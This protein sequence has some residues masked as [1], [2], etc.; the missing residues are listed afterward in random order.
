[1]NVITQSPTNTARG[2]RAV[3]RRK[4]RRRSD[5]GPRWRSARHEPAARQRRRPAGRPRRLCPRPQPSRPPAGRR[6]R[7]RA[8]RQTA[9]DR[10]RA[11]RRAGVR[12]CHPPESDAADL[13]QGAGGQARL[14]VDNPAD[15][16]E[17]RTLDARRV[18]HIQKA[19]ALRDDLASVGGDHADQPDRVSVPGL[20]SSVND[21]DITELDVAVWT[22]AT[23]S[24]NGP[25]N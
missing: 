19:C 13:R 20:S 8:P 14:P 23:S 18:G 10:Q 17:V 1:M 25:R 7:R 12:R 6:G 3:R 2:V 24:T 16:H 9:V 15:L 22:V 11:H 21:A 4:S 5:G